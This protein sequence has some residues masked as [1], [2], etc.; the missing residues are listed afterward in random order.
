M[1]YKQNQAKLRGRQKTP[2]E[3]CGGWVGA[4][5]AGRYPPPG[6]SVPLSPVHRCL[7]VLALLLL[8][9]RRTDPKDVTPV[10][11]AC[12]CVT[13]RDKRDLASETESAI[14]MGT[15]PAV[16][17]GPRPAQVL[18]EGAEG[19]TEGTRASGPEDGARPLPPGPTR[20][21]ARRPSGTCGEEFPGA[22]RR[23]R[24]HSSLR[25][26]DLGGQMAALGRVRRP[27]GPGPG[28]RVGGSPSGLTRCSLR[29]GVSSVCSSFSGLCQGGR[30]QCDACP[31]PRGPPLPA[32]GALR[33]RGGPAS[34]REPCSRSHSVCTSSRKPRAC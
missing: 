19:Q 10:L 25:F 28:R 29:W 17:A 9:R 21:T 2:Q 18:L 24:V 8:G 20:C 13:S 30:T 27:A 14:G 33:F 1:D 6:P 22:V 23:P 12:D 16:R 32:P 11:R 31:G 4:P 5:E 7:E 15:C 34:S 3:V 26:P